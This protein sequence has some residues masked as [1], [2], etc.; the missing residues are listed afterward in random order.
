MQQHSS[1]KPSAKPRLKPE[2]EPVAIVP[3]TGVG[4]GEVTL[5]SSAPNANGL[6]FTPATCPMQ[7]ET[8][9]SYR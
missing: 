2:A 9:G 5:I 8:S 4:L 6:G 7:R 1:K 3:A